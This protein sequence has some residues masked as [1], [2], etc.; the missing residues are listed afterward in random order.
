[1]ET[2]KKAL[3]KKVHY[4]KRMIQKTYIEI[5]RKTSLPQ[6][7]KSPY[8]SECI[9]ICRKLLD[10]KDTILLIAPI[11][12]KRYIK[13]ERYGI[14]VIF[15]GGTIEV[16]NHVYNYT[17]KIDQKNWDLMI[18]DFNYELEERRMEF[19][20]EINK[21]IKHSLRSILKSIEQKNETE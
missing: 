19:E 21:N 12:S 15:Y 11:S 6:D 20:G 14:Y 7:P 17:I 5:H 4:L 1:M 13:N 8:Y 9:S 10:Q 3:R 2:V 16:I 18:D